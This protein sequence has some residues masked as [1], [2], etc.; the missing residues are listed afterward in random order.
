M[1]FVQRILRRRNI[2]FRAILFFLR[3]SDELI[4]ARGDILIKRRAY[5]LL[6]RISDPLNVIAA[7]LRRISINQHDGLLIFVVTRTT[8]QV[9][10]GDRIQTSLEIHNRG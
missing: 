7:C 10:V 2:S 6:E 1:F 4:G 9:N 3:V 5:T 8:K